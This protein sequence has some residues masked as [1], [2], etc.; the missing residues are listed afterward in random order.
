MPL[1][2]A[3]ID[4]YFEMQ[5]SAIFVDIHLQLRNKSAGFALSV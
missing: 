3:G 4:V 5:M 1:N 2:L